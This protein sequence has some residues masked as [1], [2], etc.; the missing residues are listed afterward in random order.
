MGISTSIF[1]FCFWV[2]FDKKIKNKSDAKNDRNTATD[3]TLESP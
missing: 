3:D 2:L 1:V